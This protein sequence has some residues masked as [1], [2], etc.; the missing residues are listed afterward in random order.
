M[1]PMSIDGAGVLGARVGA[2]L[3][4]LGCQ[5]DSYGRRLSLQQAILTA[6]SSVCVAKCFYLTIDWRRTSPLFVT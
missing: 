3:G 2:E 4:A 5:I 1:K 6:P